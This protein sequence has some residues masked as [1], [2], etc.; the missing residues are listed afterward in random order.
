MS[1]EFRSSLAGWLRFRVSHEAVVDNFLEWQS[2]EVLTGLRAFTSKIAPSYGRWQKVSLHC[3]LLAG[4]FSYLSDPRENVK[5][6]AKC[7][8]VLISG[9]THCHFNH[10]LF[11]KSESLNKYSPHLRERELGFTC[12]G[13]NIKEFVCIF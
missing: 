4:G 7:L 5:N 1:Q 3:R 9:V 10:I 2:F 13:R 12:A 8:C 6:I 11:I